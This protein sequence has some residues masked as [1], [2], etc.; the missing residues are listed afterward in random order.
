MALE[1]EGLIYCAKEFSQLECS[2]SALHV[3]GYLVSVNFPSYIVLVMSL[4]S[5]TKQGYMTL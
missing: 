5:Y 1:F 4:V 2:H 3:I